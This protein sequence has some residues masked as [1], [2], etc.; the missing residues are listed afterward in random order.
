MDP[1]PLLAKVRAR[2]DL[3]DPSATVRHRPTFHEVLVQ[4]PDRYVTFDIEGLAA[5]LD[6]EAAFNGLVD[7]QL[8]QRLRGPR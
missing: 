3:I 7:M 4:F 2:V 1:T 8:R 5:C 6:D